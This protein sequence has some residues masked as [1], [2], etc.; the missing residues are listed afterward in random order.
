MSKVTDNR[1]TVEQQVVPTAVYWKL[2]RIL[3]LPNL[4]G[5]SAVTSPSCCPP[6]AST[7]QNLFIPTLP[8]G[9]WRT[10][11]RTEPGV[12]ALLLLWLC[13]EPLPQQPWALLKSSIMKWDIISKHQAGCQRSAQCALGHSGAVFFFHCFQPLLEV[14]WGVTQ[15]VA[16]KVQC[17]G[18]KTGGLELSEN[19]S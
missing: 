11:A 2:R 13:V 12:A 19:P 14:N 1:M 7:A 8:L 6:S 16:W 10:Q 4:N 9:P 5:S 15:E 3:K 17:S 18:P